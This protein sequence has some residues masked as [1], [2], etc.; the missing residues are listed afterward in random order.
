MII[1]GLASLIENTLEDLLSPSLFPE[2][3]MGAAA[4]YAVLSGGTRLRPR[5]LIAT[6][7]ALG[8]P[9]TSTLHP[10]CALELIHTYSLIHDD[11]P[12]MDDDDIR[13]GKPSLHKV[14]PEWHA[15]LTGDFLLTYA[16]E[17]LAKSPALSADIR[18]RLVETV[19]KRAGALGMI[20]G[21]EKDMTLTGHPLDLATLE[22]VHKNKTAALIT[23]ALESG[24]IIANSPDISPLTQIGEKLGLAFQII[25]D[26]LDADTEDEQPSI[27]KILG[28]TQARTYAEELYQSALRLIQKLPQPASELETLAHHLV[29]RNS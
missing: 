14:Y 5:L 26:V 16:F 22:S 27:V 28:R 12:C 13:R 29:F 2:G 20:G 4:R 23:C 1:L 21:Q 24:G 10:A 17:V 9:L 7:T 11:L 3:E 15:L 25:D 18:L 8:A 19:A 6:A